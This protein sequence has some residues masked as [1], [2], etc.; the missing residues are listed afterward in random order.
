MFYFSIIRNF[1]RYKKIILQNKN[2]NLTFTLKVVNMIII[3]IRY[4]FIS[5]GTKKL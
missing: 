4:L 2:M 1:G 3:I 5:L